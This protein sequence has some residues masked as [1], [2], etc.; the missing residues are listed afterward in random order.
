MARFGPVNALYFPYWG[1][2]TGDPLAQSGWA[3]NSPF[4]NHI[5]LLARTGGLSSGSQLSFF[6]DSGT[7]SFQW[8]AGPVQGRS[9][10]WTGKER[11]AKEGEK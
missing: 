11:Q 4:V 7:G 6:V 9:E 1:L 3:A 10:K 5:H 8:G 2:H